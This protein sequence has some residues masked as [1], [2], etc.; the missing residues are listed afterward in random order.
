MA[1]RRKSVVGFPRLRHGPAYQAGGSV[2]RRARV[3]LSL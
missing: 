2:C 1:P 3:L